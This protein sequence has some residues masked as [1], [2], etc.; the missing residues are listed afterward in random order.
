MKLILII[1]LF[2]FGN[3]AYSQ[4]T[5][6]TGL[7]GDNLDLNALTELFKNS[8]DVEDFEK[9]LN[10]ENSEVNNL[11]LNDDGQV[12]YIKVVDH[13]DS[14]AHALVLQVDVDESESQDVAVIE[15]EQVNEEEV[16]LQVIGDSELYGEEYMIEPADSKDD[17]LVVN[18]RNWRAVKHIY[19]PRYVVW[20]SPWRY[21]KHPHWYKPWKRANWHAYHK[22]VHKHHVHYRRA[23]NHRLKHAHAHYHKHKTSSPKFHAKHSSKKNKTVSTK[24]KRKR[25]GGTIKPK[26]KSKKKTRNKKHH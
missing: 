25:P 9:Q 21:N 12:D 16:H 1:S 23:H 8:K 13:T 26:T 17:Q 22:R 7:E 24:N 5:D 20:V 2:F 14:T 6:S 4:E 10:S 3:M 15:M 11:D 19:S 18:V